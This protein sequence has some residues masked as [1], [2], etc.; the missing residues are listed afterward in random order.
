MASALDILDDL[1]PISDLS[2]GRTSALLQR[3]DHDPVILIK[4]NKPSYVLM[5]IENYRA[6]MEQIEDN[7]D[8]LLAEKRLANSTSK[9][10]SNEGSWPISA[11][12]K[13]PCRG[14]NRNSHE[15]AS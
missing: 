14:P 2:N 11:F 12:P 5:N 4:R 13:R 1:A 9:T 7:E 10:I 8:L 6:L 3:A 15:L